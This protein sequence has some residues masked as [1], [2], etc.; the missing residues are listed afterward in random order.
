[1]SL[2]DAKH[3][4]WLLLTIVICSCQSLPVVL[5]AP[6]TKGLLSSAPRS[7][8]LNVDRSPAAIPCRPLR[9]QAAPDTPTEFL[10]RECNLYR[11]L[12]THFAHPTQLE[13][14][15]GING[16]WRQRQIQ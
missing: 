14:V 2:P 13:R 11:Q 7:R 16:H 6:R 15:S 4:S 12:V 3:P 9:I 10:M 1:M 5:V 8:C